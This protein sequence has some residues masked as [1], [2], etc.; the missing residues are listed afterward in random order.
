MLFS[1]VYFA[2]HPRP[3]TLEGFFSAKPLCLSVSA[4]ESSVLAPSPFSSSC[5]N[6]FIPN[7][8]QAYLHNGRIPTL[9][10]STCSALF[11]SRRRGSPSIPIVELIPPLPTPFSFNGLREPIL[12]PLSFQFHPGM[13][14]TPSPRRSDVPIEAKRRSQPGRHRADV[15]KFPFC[16]RAIID[17][18]PALQP[19]K[20]A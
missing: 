14:G 1:P 15:R 4:R 18:L 20:R 8:L 7:L 2:S 10:E 19:R 3:F 13:G 5:P 6:P 17:L 9:L 16:R 11:S 12:Q